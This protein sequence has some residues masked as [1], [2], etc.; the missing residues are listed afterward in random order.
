MDTSHLFTATLQL[1]SPWKVESVDFRDADGG[2]QKPRIMIGFEPGARFHCRETGCRETVRPVH[3][4]R[5]RVWRHLNFF[6]YK[7]FIHA[8]MPRV[9]CP[10]HGVRTVSAP[11]G[12]ARQRVHA[13][14]RGVGRGDGPPPARRYARR[15][16]G[17]DRHPFVAVHRP[18]RRRGKEA[19]GPHGSGGHRHRRDQPQGSQ[20]HHRGR[21]P[22]RARRDRRDPGQGPRPSSNGSRGTSWTTT[23]SRNMCVWP[24]AT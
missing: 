20:L 3:D 19:R 2:R 21:R 10:V 17:R 9:T 5:E 15:A 14:V 18:L 13:P 6:Q 1:Q 23:G 4:R 11:V 7:A 16:I 12:Q 8:A 24:P 22:R